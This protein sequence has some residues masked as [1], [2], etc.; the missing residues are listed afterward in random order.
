MLGLHIT[1]PVESQRSNILD[2]FGGSGFP[3][4]DITDIVERIFG[5]VCIKDE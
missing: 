1:V 2:Q 5:P 3:V 4:V